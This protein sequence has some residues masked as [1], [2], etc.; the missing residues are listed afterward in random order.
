MQFK[1]FAS[2]SLVSA[3]G[4]FAPNTEQCRGGPG[5]TSKAYTGTA[6]TGQTLALSFDGGPTQSTSQIGDFLY[7]NSIRATFFVRGK[8]IANAGDELARLKARGHLVGQQGYSGD[9]LTA[10][11]E[12]ALEVRKTDALISP[13]VTGN[14]FLLRPPAGRFDDELARQLNL[15]GLNKYV[16]PIAWDVGAS[17]GDFVDD[18][19]CLNQGQDPAV[20]AQNYLERLRSL[21][22]GIVRFSSERPALLEFIQIIVTKLRDEGFQFVRIDEVPAIRLAIERAGG[23][24][25][26]IAGPDGCNE[27]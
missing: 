24:P 13:Y 9:V 15:A 10:V 20:C 4:V 5:L 19:D 26:T 27:Y 8:E 12:P 17:S 6:L 1:L 2:L 23:K 3:C 18:H 14:I 7:G 22:H 16:G 25:G 21:E 11:P